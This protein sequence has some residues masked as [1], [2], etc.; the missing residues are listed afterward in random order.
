MGILFLMGVIGLPNY[1]C[2]WS[3]RKELRQP[4]IADVMSRNR[5]EMLTKYFH[6]NDNTTQRPRGSPEHDKLHKVRPMIDH[7]KRVF[8][9]HYAPHQNIAV[10]EAMIKFK[11]RCSFLQYIPSKPCKWGIKAWALADSESFYLVNFDVYVG[12]DGADGNA[13]NNIPLGTRVVTKLVE[14]YYKKRHHVYFDNYFTSVKL[15]ESLA[16]KKT[17]ATGTVRKER[18][19][20]P[21]PMKS[22]KMKQS[23]EMRKWQKGRMM[24]VSWQEKKRQVNVL[25]SRNVTG[26]MEL[27]RPGKRGQPEQRYLK[28]ITIQDYTENFNGV[29]KSDQLRQYY[30]IANKANK[31][32]KYL[33]WF[34]CDVTMVNAYILYKEG[35]GGPRPKPNTHL[36]FHLEVATALVAGF[37]SRKRRASGDA[38]EAAV[39]KTPTVHES[40]KITTTRGIRNCVLCPR[41]G[42]FTAAGNK[43]Q[44][45]FECVKCGVA[46]CKDRG[47]FAAFHQYQQ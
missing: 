29:D 38:P 27:R 5:Y 18:L 17:Y 34:L 43:I 39:I 12:K 44:S 31:W 42:R 32:W 33:F 24:A 1:R 36:H 3:S 13:R 15:V 10:G 30:G 40:T 16:R 6:L 41:E 11:G 7:A 26:N 22:L 23:G 37:T 28:P 35:P 46:L 21:V 47:C 8:C 25:T 45:S 20:L 14:P 2:Y 19:G 4:V 9:Q